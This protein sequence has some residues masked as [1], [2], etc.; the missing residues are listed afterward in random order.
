MSYLLR[1]FLSKNILIPK[2]YKTVLV[3]QVHSHDFYY[4]IPE[5]YQKS[6]YLANASLHDNIEWYFHRGVEAA[7]KKYVT[8]IKYVSPCLNNDTVQK[9]A[10]NSINTLDSTA[11]I[12]QL[13]FPLKRDNGLVEIIKVYCVQHGLHYDSHLGGAY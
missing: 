4:E 8:Q 3:R 11:N 5:E 12:L 7:F 1:R 6:F 10:I 9:L 13:N 2:N